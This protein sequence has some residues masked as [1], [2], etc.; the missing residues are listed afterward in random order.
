MHIHQSR[1]PYLFMFSQRHSY[2][3]R[4][5]SLHVVTVLFAFRGLADVHQSLDLRDYILLLTYV[6]VAD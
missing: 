4:R 2:G 5:S 3:Q 1:L 6:M